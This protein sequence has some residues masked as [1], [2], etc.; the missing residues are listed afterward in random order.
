MKKII[1]LIVF[2]ICITSKATLSQDDKGDR[3][4]GE[5][6]PPAGVSEEVDNN[7]LKILLKKWIGREVSVTEQYFEPL[8]NL[9]Y[10]VFTIEPI[11]IPNR[12]HGGYSQILAI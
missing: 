8:I 7:L 4:V 6:I 10:I 5:L 3:C 9:K 12:V 11:A 2:F 1:F